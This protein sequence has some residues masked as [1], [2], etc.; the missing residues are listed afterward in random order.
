MEDCI[1]CKIAVKET[2]AEIVYEDEQFI[3]FPDSNPKA[4]FHV[5]LIPKKHIPSLREVGEDDMELMGR[6]LL[7]AQKVAQEN[8][9]KGYK[10]AMHVG[11]E[12]GQEVD[13]L[14]L[15]LLAG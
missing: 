1:F 6:L 2:Q 13:H 10:L 5:L 3:V 7:T 9:L 14:H 15:H 4:P 8:H 12:G 11:K